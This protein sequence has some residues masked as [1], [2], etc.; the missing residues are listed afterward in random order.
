[1]NLH[2]MLQQREADGNPLRIGIIGAGKFGTMFLSQVSRTPGMH[3]VGIADLNP[4]TVR[5]SLKRIGW[6]ASH[7]NA[8]SLSSAHK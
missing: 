2:S 4:N 5:K 3:L 6:Q 1:M 8:K 7:Y